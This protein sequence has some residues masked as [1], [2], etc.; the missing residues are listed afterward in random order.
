MS[1]AAVSWCSRQ[2]EVVA[3]SSTE[4]EYIGLC[5]VGKD[6]VWVRR[7][8]RG[9]GIEKLNLGKPLVINADNQG[10]MDLARNCVSSK[11]TKHIDVRY[12]YIRELVENDVVT[13]QYCPT[14]NMVADML[15][16]PLGSTKLEKFRS[17]C[18]LIR[19]EDTSIE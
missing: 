17:A 7:L 19:I 3:L 13:F 12:H 11:R 2:Q 5:S 1:G 10:S 9:F 15:T 4:A 18:G 16:K 14:D 6:A 8:L